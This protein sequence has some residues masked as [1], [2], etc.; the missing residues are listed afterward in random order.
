MHKIKIIVIVGYILLGGLFLA[1]MYWI[2]ENWKK[3]VDDFSYRPKS[4]KEL[5][6]LSNTLTAMYRAEGTSGLLTIVRDPQL[7]Q[8]YDSLRIAITNQINQFK[9]ISEDSIINVHLDSLEILFALK[10][11]NTDKMI[12]LS[13]SFETETTQEIIKKNVLK[14]PD[15]DRLDVLLNSIPTVEQSQDTNVVLSERRG[16]FRRIGDAIRASERDTIR[17]VHSQSILTQRE[18]IIPAIRDTIIE[19]IQ[20][21]NQTSQRYNAII[22]AKLLRKQNEL[23]TINEQITSEIIFITKKLENN[24][25]VRNLDIITKQK[26]DIRSS[27]HEMYFISA[28]AALILF[29]FIFLVI[30]SLSV[31]ERLY[32]QIHKSQKRIEDLLASRELLLLSIVHDIKAPVGSVIGYLELMRKDD[33]SPQHRSYIENIQHSISHVLDLISNLLDF[34]SL[35]SNEQNLEQV[36]FSPYILLSNIYQSFVPNVQTKN[37][38]FEFLPEINEEVQYISD[39]YCIQKIVNNVISNAIKYTPAKGLIVLSAQLLQSKSEPVQLVITVQDTGPGIKKEDLQ[40][41]FEAFERLDYLGSTIEGLGIGLNTS[42][43]MAQLLGGSITVDSTIGQGSTFT[44]TLPLYPITTAQFSSSKPINILFIDDD[45]IQLDLLSRITR[46]E[47]MTP[48]VCLR[49]SN[50]LQLLHEKHFDIIFSDIQMPEMNGLELVKHIRIAKFGETGTIPIIGLS[51]RSDIS[52]EQYRMAGFSDFLLKPF[53]SDQ[54]LQIIYQ[55]VKVDNAPVSPP[56][57][58]EKIKGFEALIEFAG[59][60]WK[61]GKSIIQSFIKENQTNYQSLKKALARDD[62]ETIYNISHKMM[63]IMKMIGDE[64]L[65]LLLKKHVVGYQDKKNQTELLKLIKSHLRQ[66]ALFVKQM[67]NKLHT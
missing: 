23:Y 31:R 33:P 64:R 55:Y 17:Q 8:K 4:Q 32:N 16:L 62:W 6:M 5:V 19:M 22:T 66:A 14:Q 59:D 25:Y 52:Q 67:N 43:K 53:T 7:N 61:S 54:L 42:A 38:Q 40:R 21:I 30:R 39:P 56:I 37:I 28:I 20:E 48:Y 65:I 24:E 63:P 13:Q 11:I 51:A 50:A 58:P 12:R 10:K 18:V 34:H 60:D 1:A 49:A 57:N 3:S 44:I 36:K 47:G 45:A 46:H 15:L 27:L 9:Q 41:I 35:K 26:D 29:V 2:Y